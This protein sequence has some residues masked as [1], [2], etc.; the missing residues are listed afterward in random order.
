MSIRN[1]MRFSVILIASL[2]IVAAPSENVFASTA[3]EMQPQSAYWSKMGDEETYCSELFR[4]LKDVTTP[5]PDLIVTRFPEIYSGVHLMDPLKKALK[6][7]GLDDQLC[8]P[9]SPMVSRGVP[10]YFR[11]FKLA[12]KA[13]HEVSVHGGDDFSHLYLLTDGNDMVIGVHFVC[14]APESRQEPNTDFFYF[15]FPLSK[16]RSSTITRVRWETE[17]TGDMLIL[18]GWHV[19]IKDRGRCL[20]FNRWHLPKRVANFIRYVLE[21]KLGI[22]E[23]ET[24]A[25]DKGADTV[26][27]EG[28]TFS[29]ASEYWA[30]T[31]VKSFFMARHETTGSDWHR[32]RTWAAKN[33]YDIGDAAASD[34]DHPVHSVTWSDIMKWCNARSEKEGLSPVYYAGGKVC[35]SGTLAKEGQYA[36]VVDRKANGYRLPTEAEWEW[37]E[38]GG[39]LSKGRA[40]SG[41]NDLDEVAWWRGTSRGAVV[42]LYRGWGTW[43]VGQKK[44]NELGIHDMWGNVWELCSGAMSESPLLLGRGGHWGEVKSVI[45]G[46]PALG[47]DYCSVADP[48][49]SW[50]GNTG[51]FR[52]ARNAL[53]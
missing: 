1:R 4:L 17:N 7:L 33:G 36:V 34:N 41:S 37:A 9:A 20:E 50:R 27:V 6:K 42:D 30:G 38:R 53:P 19:H 24:A 52:V 3:V 2:G 15:D 32:V 39:N 35:R 45:R 5:D 12:E 44:P 14:L 49:E 31:M 26:F 8:P 22:A 46:R 10:F 43:P 13:R 40:Y 18:K 11:P 48:P 16:K 47:E 28:G 51:G 29:G 21:L 23:R 25:T